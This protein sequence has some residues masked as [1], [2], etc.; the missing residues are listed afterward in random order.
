MDHKD[1]AHRCMHSQ[2][3]E[4]GT[5]WVCL[6][7]SCAEIKDCDCYKGDATWY[8]FLVVS[9]CYLLNLTFNY[10]F[11]IDTNMPRYKFETKYNLA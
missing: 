10:N 9:T 8:S 1:N 5:F 11:E 4:L 3:S 2:T 7:T 6:A